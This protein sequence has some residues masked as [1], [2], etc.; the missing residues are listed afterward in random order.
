MAKCQVLDSL[1][2]R[3]GGIATGMWRPTSYHFAFQGAVVLPPADGAITTNAFG[4][5]GAARTPQALP[6]GTGSQW[7]DEDVPRA[8]LFVWHQF[9][10][11]DFFAIKHALQNL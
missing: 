5:A 9:R 3:T 4:D 7:P 2:S 1:P 8:W 10:S 6:R 11:C